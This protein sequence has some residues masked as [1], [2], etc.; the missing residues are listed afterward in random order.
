MFTLLVVHSQKRKNWKVYETG[1]TY[2]I[3]KNELDK[4]CFQH[5][6]DYG[7][8]KY[9]AKGTQSDKV[10]RGKA[11]KIASDPKYDGYQRGLASTVYKLFD[12]KSALLNKSSGSGIVNEPNDQLANKLHEPIVKK[13][14]K[15]KVYSFFRDNIWG[16]DLADVQSLSKYNKG[17]KYLSCTIDLFSKYS[18]IIPIKYKK[19]TS[20]ANAFKK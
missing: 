7:K 2:F 19:G 9:L 18:W 6:M 17:I 15:R 16:V 4:A 20:I 1:N 13:L 8:T 14:K 11:F 5:D 3:Y 12:K 10:L